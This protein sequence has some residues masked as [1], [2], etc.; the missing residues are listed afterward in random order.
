MKIIKW[1]TL[2]LIGILTIYSGY[3]VVGYVLLG[4]EY[5]RIIG[6]TTSRFL[7]MFFMSIGSGIVFAISL[8]LFILLLINILKN[9]KIS[10]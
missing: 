1:I 10:K 4:N 3:S 7:G 5:P 8:T 6:D 9:R 2:C